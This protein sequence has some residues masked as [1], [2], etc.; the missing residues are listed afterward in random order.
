MY[1]AASDEILSRRQI[2]GYI[3]GLWNGFS[4]K[5]NN[6]VFSHNNA[7]SGYVG[8]VNLQLLLSVRERETG[9]L[10]DMSQMYVSAVVAAV[11]VS[12]VCC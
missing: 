7:L 8:N 4:A 9:E 2:K 5:R 11:R 3:P 10:V 12:V 6:N 1:S